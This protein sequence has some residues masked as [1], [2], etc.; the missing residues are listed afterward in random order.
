MTKRSEHYVGK[1]ETCD[2]LIG[3][4]GF[5]QTPTECILHIGHTGNHIDEN[6]REE[7]QKSTRGR[8]L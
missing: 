6:G 3:M 7:S 4:H 2:A 5:L 8:K 1:H